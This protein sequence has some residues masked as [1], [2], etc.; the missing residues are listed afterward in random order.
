[1]QNY[2]WFMGIDVSKEKLDITLL[3][4]CEKRHYSMIENSVV[5]IKLFI[6]ELKSIVGFSMKNCLVCM[7]H[8]G[9]YNSHLLTVSDAQQWS[10]C[11]ES[12]VQ[13]KQSGGL[14]RGKNDIVDSY[15]IALYAYKN[16]LFLKL[17]QAP[18]EIIL[19]L[20]KLSGIRDRLINAKKQLERTIKE[21]KAFQNKT[22]S[23]L[24][25]S[26]CKKSVEAIAND[27][28]R[29]EDE[30]QSVIES[31]PELTRLFNI[32]E[33][34]PGIGRV[35][36]TEI[37]VTTNEF[38]SINDARKYA[39]YAGVAPF[40]YTSGSSIRG[41]TRTSKKANL[42]V[43]SRLHMASLVAAVHCEEL[44]SYYQR[45]VAEGKNK[46]SVLNAV[47]NKLVHRIFACVNDNRLYEK[48]YLQNYLVEP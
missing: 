24:L 21:D 8:T 18:R 47:K 19:K 17:W 3:E 6:K 37:V 23:K 34:V 30:I 48:K 33:S 28:V 38:K 20:K 2:Q 35:S 22:I 12:A 32:I 1:M 29:T 46:M 41:K 26:C 10:L 13:I 44:K 45:K 11:L 42:Q 15:R 4:G 16:Q 5:G 31:D 9:I 14:Q 40:E 27:I 39:C 43:K 36:A 25:E 7:E